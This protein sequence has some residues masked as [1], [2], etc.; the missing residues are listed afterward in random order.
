MSKSVEE[1]SKGI[2]EKSKGV[3]EKKGRAQNSMANDTCRSA[4][5]VISIQENVQAPSRVLQTE[6]EYLVLV[7][8]IS[9]SW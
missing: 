8:R 1:K 6:S 7:V 4:F 5:Y 9:Q 3:Q 2:Q